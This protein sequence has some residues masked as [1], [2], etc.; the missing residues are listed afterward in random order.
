MKSISYIIGLALF[1]LIALNSC[2]E[3][4]TCKYCYATLYNSNDSLI[5]KETVPEEICDEDEIQKRE[6]EKIVD[7]Q[8]GN[9]SRW[10]CVEF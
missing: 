10:D 1:A 2:Q 7:P 9:I 4:E 8:S 5:S 3:E 6:S